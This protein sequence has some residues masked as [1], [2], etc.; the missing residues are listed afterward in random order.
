M[1]VEKIVATDVAAAALP[2]VEAAIL[3]AVAENGRAVVA[4]P[5]GSSP[6]PLFRALRSSD[7]PWERLWVAFGDER[8]VPLDHEHS[9]A[10][11]AIRELLGHV[12][13][14]EGQVLTWPILDDPAES[15]HA[16][17][18]LLE[19]ALGAFPIF[20]LNLL[21]LGDD[22]HTASLFPGTGAALLE[23]PTLAVHAPDYV[24]PGG[25]RLSLS[26]SALSASQHVL[27]L[28]VGQNKLQALRRTFGDLTTRADGAHGASPTA[29][30]AE[31]G[32]A[33]LDANPARA[34]TALRRLSV[35]TDVSF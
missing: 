10:G 8:F 25:W 16:Y 22:G 11:A 24:A 3:N 5:G 2:L 15:A 19:R 12:P 4:L 9:N 13:V 14:P 29:A 31:A 17:R 6:L 7:L 28:V 34:I 35:V 30:G 27:F 18:E 33:E 32:A 21:G 23:G 26:A 20:D 1:E